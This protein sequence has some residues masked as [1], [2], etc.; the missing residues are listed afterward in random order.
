M[1]DFGVGNSLR[2]GRLRL[3]PGSRFLVENGGDLLEPFRESK[4][5]ESW[6]LQIYCQGMPL[7]DESGNLEQSL[8]ELLWPK[9]G[10]FGESTWGSAR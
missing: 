1:C 2:Q 5:Y 10:L 4:L 3:K 8:R 9:P 6:D 7:R